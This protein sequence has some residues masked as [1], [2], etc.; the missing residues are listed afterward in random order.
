MYLL[1]SSAVAQSRDILQTKLNL[2]FGQFEI[3]PVEPFSMATTDDFLKKRTGDL[4][5]KE[6]RSFLTAVTNGSPF[7]LDVLTRPLTKTSFPDPGKAM[8]ESFKTT[9]MVSPGILSQYFHSLLSQLRDSKKPETLDS[10]ELKIL[11]V[12]ADKK[13][14]VGEIASQSSL[15]K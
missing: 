10:K 1:A 9:L 7:Y 2:L 12:V 14:R 11:L 3:V 5:P 4:L 6:Y 8:V 15:S 13:R